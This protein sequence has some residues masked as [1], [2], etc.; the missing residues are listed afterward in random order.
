MGTK[1]PCIVYQLHSIFEGH[2]MLIHELNVVSNQYLYFPIKISQ[3][4]F[5]GFRITSITSKRI[6]L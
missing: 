5:L 1:Q 3:D 4:N 6:L 2:L